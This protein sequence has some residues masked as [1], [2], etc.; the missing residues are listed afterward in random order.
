[1][2]LFDSMMLKNDGLLILFYLNF[3]VNEEH[4][5]ILGKTKFRDPRLNAVS[6]SGH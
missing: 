1:M 3:H 5:Y 4:T 2:L 6:M